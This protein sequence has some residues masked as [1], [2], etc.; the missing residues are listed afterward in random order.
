MQEDLLSCLG[1]Q[2]KW[3]LIFGIVLIILGIGGFLLRSK[4]RP[5]QAGLQIET[6]PVSTVY[7]NNEQVGTTPYESVRPPGDITL[8]LVP[9]PTDKNLAPW[10]TKLNLTEGIKTIVK[11]DFGETESASAGE[12]LSF[13]KLS[14]GRTSLA[15]VSSPDSAQITLDGQMRGYTP[16]PVDPVGVGDH[17]LVVSQAGYQDREIQA[18]AESGYKLTVIAMLAQKPQEA[19]ESGEASESGQVA[20]ESTSDL[21]QSMV[22]ILDTPTGFLRVREK[23]TSASTESAQ[24]KPGNKYP[25]IEQ[26]D[27]GDWYK[28]EYTKGKQGWIS[29]QYAKK[30]KS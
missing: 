20:G 24:V 19:L 22:Q 5:A 6:N 8:R 2:R 4:I 18:R 28:I 25:F 7:I 30:V 29:A 13:E 21:T 11:R 23:P 10:S 15:V 17:K 27:K 1:M 14:G 26:N 16:L 12:V 3:I 9:A